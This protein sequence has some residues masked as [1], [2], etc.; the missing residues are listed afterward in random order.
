M[1]RRFY[2]DDRTIV[3]ISSGKVRGC[4]LND[5]YYFRGIPYCDAER[6]EMPTPVKPWDGVLDAVTYGPV[7]PTINKPSVQGMNALSQQ[8]L[9]GYRFW[10][11]DEKCQYINVWTKKLDPNAKRPVMVWIHGGGFSAGSSVEQMSYDGKNLCVDG[12][13]VIVSLNHRLNLLGYLDFSEFGEKYWNSGN[14]GMADIIEALK[15]VKTNIAQFGGD[16]DNVTLFGQSGG[17]GKIRTLL[18]TPAADGLYNRVIFQSGMGD[19]PGPEEPAS[20]E[21]NR[22]LARELVA[23]LGLTKET[24]EEIKKFTF[25]ELRAAF[26]EVEKDNAAKGLRLGMALG[27]VPNG[28]YLGSPFS[29]GLSENAKKT[30]CIAGSTL[31]EMSLHK[32]PFIPYDTPDDIRDKKLEGLYGSRKDEMIAKFNEAYPG[33]NLWDL[34]NI[35]SVTRLKTLEFLDMKAEYDA[36]IYNYLI[37]YQLNYWGGLPAYHGFCLPLAFGNTEY[38]DA[39]N[40]P[41]CVALSQKMHQAWINFATNG[42]PNG[43]DVP[44][45]K[46]FKKGECGTM[47]FDRQCGMRNNHDRDLLNNYRDITGIDSLG[48]I[49]SHKEAD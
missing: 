20:V 23:K 17:G 35:D 3:E 4:Y 29:V 32:M 14:S 42:N 6:F 49:L 18:Q 11:E 36:P 13:L 33:R 38:V 2:C 10:P 47:I 9:F 25:E 41:D 21:I 7:A 46:Q 12:D 31:A 24:F 1:N 40:E 5:H 44:E 26:L 16:P 34:Y 45:W 8:P 43:G 37:T 48:A 28:W 15:W 19:A 22:Q 30:P 27:P 39:C